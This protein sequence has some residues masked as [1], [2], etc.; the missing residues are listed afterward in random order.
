MTQLDSERSSNTNNA[1]TPIRRSKK[2][3][4]GSDQRTDNDQE[5]NGNNG[6]PDIVHEVPEVY[7]STTKKE[8]RKIELPNSQRP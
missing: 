3:R 7:E 1:I 4:R 6:I 8:N 2:E 5:L